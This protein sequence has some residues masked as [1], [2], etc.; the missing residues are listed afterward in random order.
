MT[1][2]FREWAFEVDK[3]TTE[4]A[5]KAIKGSAVQECGCTYC[6]NFLLQ[7]ETIYPLEVI[8]FFESVGIDYHKESDVSE[9]GELDNGL[10]IYMSCFHFAGKI[11]RG[12]SSAFALP[13]GGYQLNLT[14]LDERVKIGFWKS[15]DGKSEASLV[16]VEL[17][18]LLPWVLNLETK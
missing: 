12:E 2:E 15:S 8:S 13:M 7:R 5:Y 6:Q 3:Q 17:E 11:I 1:I 4:K 9:Y 16:E 14:P 18:V 10:R